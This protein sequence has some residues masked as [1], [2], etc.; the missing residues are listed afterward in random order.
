MAVVES[1]APRPVSA[2]LATAWAGQKP[3]APPAR[4]RA[5]PGQ[6][7]EQLAA[8]ARPG[9]VAA[10]PLAPVVA[11]EQAGPRGRPSARTAPSEGT[12][13]A[14]FT[15]ADLAPGGDLPEGVEHAVPPGP[16]DVVLERPG[17][18]RP[19]LV[20]DPGP[21]EHGAV[22][23]GGDGLDRG[24]PD[25]DPDGDVAPPGRPGHGA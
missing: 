17:L 19:H 24:G 11:V 4:W 16:V 9:R 3:A 13:A 25:V 20:R 23:V 18:G 10:G 15:A 5:V 8:V 7:G 2:W 22:G 14:T 12:M 1:M 21:G 6:E